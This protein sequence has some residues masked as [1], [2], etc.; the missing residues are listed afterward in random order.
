MLGYLDWI[1]FLGYDLHSYP[2][3]QK[4]FISLH[5]LTYPYISLHILRYPK[6]SWQ[7]STSAVPQVNVHNVPNVHKVPNQHRIYLT[8]SGWRAQ[9]VQ[10]RLCQIRLHHVFASS[11]KMLEPAWQV[12]TSCFLGT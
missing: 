10:S 11:P 7:T 4:I 2:N 8:C 5:I 1:S 9:P 12:C 6:I 3:S